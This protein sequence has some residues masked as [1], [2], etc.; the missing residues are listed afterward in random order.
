MGSTEES[1]TSALKR[2]RATLRQHL[3]ADTEP[4][5][6][7]GSA[8]EKELIER[9]THAYEA[10]DVDAI[11][12]LFTAEAWLTMPPFPLQYQGRE[13]IGRF[14]AEIAFRGQRTYR[15]VATRANGQLALD[16]YLH[17]A[18]PDAQANGLLV[19]TLAG[20]RIS[21]M[22]RFEAGLLPRFCPP[23]S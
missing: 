21:A 9:L 10:G 22:T 12:A 17:G 7:P 16:A 6:Q 15:L 14:L 1:V 23:P 4:P 2:A 19:L 11:V 18:P 8:A 13:L 3:P 20:S 5:P